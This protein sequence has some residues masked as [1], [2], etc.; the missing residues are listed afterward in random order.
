[1]PKKTFLGIFIFVIVV[2]PSVSLF[3]EKPQG[4]PKTFIVLKNLYNDKASEYLMYSQYSKRAYSEGYPRL[5]Y[6]FRALASSESIC[7]ENFRELLVDMGGQAKKVTK[8][9]IK[10]SDTKANLRN[11]INTENRDINARYPSFIE[12]IKSE[13]RAGTLHVIKYAWKIKRQRLDLLQAGRSFIALATSSSIKS[14]EE[15][16]VKYFVCRIC[17]SIV[18]KLPEIICP[19]CSSSVSNYKEQ[20]RTEQYQQ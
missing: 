10:S 14:L 6:L 5:G 4:Y 9:K 7:L 17:G 19:V 16:A 11:A 1:M 3:C 2:F 13:D 18:V 8:P 20:E 15:G 12:K